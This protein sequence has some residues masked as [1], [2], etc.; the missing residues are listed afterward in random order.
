[1]SYIYD[2]GCVPNPCCQRQNV[3]HLFLI[4][5]PL[6]H[7]STNSMVRWGILGG[8]LDCKVTH[9]QLC[10]HVCICS[11]ETGHLTL[12]SN[13]YLV[14][15]IGSAPFLWD[16]PCWHEWAA[17]HWCDMVGGGARVFHLKLSRAASHPSIHASIHK[18]FL[19]PREHVY[20]R[21]CA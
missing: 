3:S 12:R 6:D 9:I 18:L 1:M 17:G 19:A 11:D 14:G 16:V 2:V 7:R 5:S 8:C 21:A 15:Q 10:L 20:V 13:H 4:S